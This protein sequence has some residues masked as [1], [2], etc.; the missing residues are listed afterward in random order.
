VPTP[1]DIVGEFPVAQTRALPVST[2]FNFGN[3]VFV[4]GELTRDATRDIESVGFVAK[5]DNVTVE[6]EAESEV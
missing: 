6:A 3:A 2:R 1:L 4:A 5:N